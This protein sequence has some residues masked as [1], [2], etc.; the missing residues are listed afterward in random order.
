M[1]C[2]HVAWLQASVIST[3]IK[4]SLKSFQE[5]V[6]LETF[7][8]SGFQQIQV[9]IQYLR[10]PLR[11]LVDDEDIIQFLLDE[12]RRMVENIFSFFVCLEDGRLK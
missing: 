12:V 1:K 6:R 5:Y 4:L 7:S 8:R 9:D 10:D 11:E 2:N 3:V